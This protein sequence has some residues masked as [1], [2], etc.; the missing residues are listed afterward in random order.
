MI[1]T[2]PL[3]SNSHDRPTGHPLATARH[4]RRSAA[5]RALAFSAV[6][7]A[8]RPEVIEQA[9]EEFASRT[10]ESHLAPLL[11][12]DAEPPLDMPFGVRTD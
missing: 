12:E 11:P 3:E 1:C 8:A 4:G 2:R 7:A 5:V 9:R 10:A 6:E